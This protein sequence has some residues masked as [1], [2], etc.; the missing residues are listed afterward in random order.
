[1]DLLTTAE[2]ARYL[3]LKERTVYDMASKRLLPCTRATGKLL[4]S[5]RLIDRWIEGRTELP[6]GASLTAPPI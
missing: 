5:R 2:V 4:F 3:R 6:A 1:M